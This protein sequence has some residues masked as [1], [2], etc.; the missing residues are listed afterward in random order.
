MPIAVVVQWYGPYHS[1]E[2][3]DADTTQY[4]ADTTRVLYMALESGNKYQYIGLTTRPDARIG[5]QHSKLAHRD[6]KRYFVGEI[7][8]QGLSGRRTHSTPPDLSLAEHALIRYL[9][10]RLNINKKSTN[11]DDVVSI[12]SCF[13][14][15]A[16]YETPIS[17]LTKFPKLLAFNPDTEEWF[18]SR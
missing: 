7:V 10:P 15:S 14:S 3:I 16:D 5:R 9:Q 8:T 12:F 11:P 2:T 13:Y 1:L 17:P 18:E 4:W 6:N